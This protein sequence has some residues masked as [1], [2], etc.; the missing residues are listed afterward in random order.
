MTTKALLMLRVD[1]NVLT[2]FERLSALANVPREVMVADALE[3][4]LD[5]HESRQNEGE[6]LRLRLLDFL[7]RTVPDR[8]AEFERCSTDYLEGL[9]DAQAHRR[10]MREIADQE[11]HELAR[12]AA[13]LA[14]EEA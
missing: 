6:A 13:E 9:V 12:R 7:K 8:A 4:G 5:L 14:P 11:E 2:R 3:A 1:P 10:A